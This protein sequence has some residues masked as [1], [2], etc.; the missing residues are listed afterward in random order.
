MSSR[1]AAVLG[2]G[3]LQFPNGIVQRLPAPLLVGEAE[4]YVNSRRISEARDDIVEH[5][6]SA[7]EIVQLDV[8]DPEQVGRIEARCGD[9]CLLKVFARTF[10]IFLRKQYLAEKGMSPC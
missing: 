10:V 1:R 7:G 8:G 5:Q 6:A 2:K 9:N 4:H 3:F